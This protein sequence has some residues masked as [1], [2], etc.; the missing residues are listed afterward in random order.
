MPRCRLETLWEAIESGEVDTLAGLNDELELIH[1]S[2]RAD[3]WIWCRWAYAACFERDLD[4]LTPADLSRLADDFAEARKKFLGLIL[5]DARKEFD[6]TMQ[7]GFGVD[8]DE[9]RGSDFEAVRGACEASS[10]VRGLQEEIDGL[11]ERV[12]RLKT[13]LQRWS[14]TSST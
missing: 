14:A 10:F 12:A 13:A 2:Y 9:A 11:E 1:A 5:L 6:E 4:E 7:V 8:E 3:A